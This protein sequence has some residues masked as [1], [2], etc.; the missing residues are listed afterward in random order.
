MPLYNLAP[1]LAAPIRAHT[2]TA[3]AKSAREAIRNRRRHA[4]EAAPLVTTH[5]QPHAEALPNNARLLIEA[6]EAAG[7][8]VRH[9]FGYYAMNAGKSNEYQAEAVRVSGMHAEARVGF[10]AVWVKGAAKLGLWYAPGLDDIGV[11]AVVSR[12][13]AM[14]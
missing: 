5:E 4:L 13:K 14:S 1:Q 8:E 3:S 10:S 9:A 12:V 6:A 7:F 2:L 11:A